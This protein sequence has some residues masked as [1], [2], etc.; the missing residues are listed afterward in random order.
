[1]RGQLVAHGAGFVP[2]WYLSYVVL[3]NS[4]CG[5]YVYKVLQASRGEFYQNWPRD[6]KLSKIEYFI[7]RI[8]LYTMYQWFADMNNIYISTQMSISNFLV[9]YQTLFKSYISW[10]FWLMNILSLCLGPWTEKNEIPV[11][12]LSRKWF[13]YIK[14]Y[15]FAFYLDYSNLDLMH[16]CDIFNR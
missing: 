11:K 15:S 7:S 5:R 12:T 13:F 9:H 3:E 16:N 1:M 2:W 8:L 14:M 6:H 4:I 10:K